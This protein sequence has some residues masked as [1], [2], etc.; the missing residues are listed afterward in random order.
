MASVPATIVLAASALETPRERNATVTDFFDPGDPAGVKRNIFSSPVP[1]ESVAASLGSATEG[2][3]PSVP[4]AAVDR[5][6]GGFFFGLRSE[7]HTSELQSLMRISYAVFCL[8]KKKR[9]INN[10]RSD[11]YS[12]N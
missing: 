3:K 2:V 1:R 6:T 5:V 11:E 9:N 4:G 8:K 12:K 7:E 10:M